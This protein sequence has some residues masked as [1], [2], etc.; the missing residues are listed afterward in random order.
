MEDL[1]AGN[2]GPG[3][4]P[5]S[6]ERPGLLHASRSSGV[7]PAPRGAGWCCSPSHHFSAEKSH[8]HRNFPFRGQNSVT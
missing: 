1:E 3:W 7:R 2:A 6:Q 5:H 8:Q 4:G